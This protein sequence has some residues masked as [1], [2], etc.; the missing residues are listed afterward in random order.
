VDW[1]A[2]IFAAGVMLYQLLTG[3]RPFTGST[4]QVAYKV[5]YESPARPAE[6]S[7]GRDLERYD[8]VVSRAL[9]KTPQDRY[10]SAAAFRAAI[11]EAYAEPVSP[12]ISEETIL[13]E[14]PRA[15]GVSDPSQP[16]WQTERSSGGNS[17]PGSRSNGADRTLLP[18]TLPPRSDPPGTRPPE[19]AETR[20]PTGAPTEWTVGGSPVPAPRSQ[21]G[22]AWAV[23]G[24]AIAVAVGVVAWHAGRSARI[25]SDV[26]PAI[27][28]VVTPTTEFP[29]RPAPPPAA[30]SAQDDAEQAARKAEEAQR[31]AAAQARAEREAAE[32][33]QRAERA[34]ADSQARA[35]A[36]ARA[37]REAAAARARAE[38]EAAARRAAEEKAR[39]DAER[40]RVI[41][42]QSRSAAAPQ[43]APAPPATQPARE[44][45][46]FRDEATNLKVASKLQFNRELLKEQITTK[47]SGG[48]VTLT[49]TVSTH[50][51]RELAG[52]IAAQVSGVV[53]VNNDLKVA[54]Q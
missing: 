30:S 49:G 17:A 23:A 40:A 14:P 29:P 20:G 37:D 11:L 34:A 13:S 41:A 15:A 46:L 26:S 39:T 38:R 35:E 48:V 7:P 44:P 32:A 33:R 4:E 31:I 42:L 50:A 8:A 43:T 6:V 1:R 16:S 3:T 22:V 9:S 47:V 2:D 12:T 5:C 19:H 10:A 51:K 45:S 18:R 52:K 24:V 25:T 36:K 27:E 53:R 28:P 21:V 54:G